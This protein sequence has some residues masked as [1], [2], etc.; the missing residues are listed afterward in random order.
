MFSNFSQLESIGFGSNV[1]L[2]NEMEIIQYVE[3]HQRNIPTKFGSNG[4]RGGDYNVKV[5]G[6]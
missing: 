6:C 3:D 1:G 4:S 2:L 5:Y